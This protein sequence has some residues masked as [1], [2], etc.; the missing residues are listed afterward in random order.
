[1]IYSGILLEREDDN[2]YPAIVFKLS[3][4]TVVFILDSYSTSEEAE[5]AALAWIER[6][7]FGGRQMTQL[8]SRP[9]SAR[10]ACELLATADA[11]RSIRAQIRFL[12]DQSDPRVEDYSDPWPILIYGDDVA[13][14][15]VAIARRMGE[16][17]IPALG[18]TVKPGNGP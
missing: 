13:D 9:D 17:D 5:K 3:A 4:A 10:F 2:G 18:Q 8:Q 12:V 1:M 7:F 11:I 6:N 14:A 15:M 16:S